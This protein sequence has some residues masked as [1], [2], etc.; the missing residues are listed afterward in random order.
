MA[1]KTP[2][3]EEFLRSQ[4]KKAVD[5]IEEVFKKRWEESDETLN[6]GDV[7]YQED[8]EDDELND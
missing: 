6:F 3:Y 7:D 5:Q 1:K 4:A 2:K 8:D